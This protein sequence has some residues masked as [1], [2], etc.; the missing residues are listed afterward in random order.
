MGHLRRGKKRAFT[1]LLGKAKKT[2]GLFLGL[3]SSKTMVGTSGCSID[4]FFRIITGWLMDASW[5]VH[6]C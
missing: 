1:K 6:G 2:P 3:P 4:D 5:M